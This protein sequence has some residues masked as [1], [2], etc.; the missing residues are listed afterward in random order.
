MGT[1][2]QA[3]HLPGSWD[4]LLGVHGGLP[5]SST[6]QVPLPP[7]HGMILESDV[8]CSP[9]LNLDPW[10]MQCEFHFSPLHEKGG[11]PLCNPLQPFATLCNP[12]KGA[13]MGVCP[14]VALHAGSSPRPHPK[15]V[16]WVPFEEWKW[17]GNSRSYS[18]GPNSWG[19]K[20][21]EKT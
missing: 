18:P 12:L 1:H 11:R 10:G 5:G 14:N 13:K 17:S 4:K 8:F 3:C 15:Q 6:P 2:H 16:F 21:S 7:P 20:R 9:L 19:P